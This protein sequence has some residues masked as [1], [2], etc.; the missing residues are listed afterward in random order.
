ML[1]KE[2]VQH[3]IHAGIA[4]DGSQRGSPDAGTA[5]ARHHVEFSDLANATG[6]CGPANQCEARCRTFVTNDEWISAAF[7]EVRVQIRIVSRMRCADAPFAMGRELGQTVVQHARDDVDR[8]L[9]QRRAPR[10]SRHAPW[11]R[12]PYADY[13]KLETRRND[14]I[15]QRPE[16]G[17]DTESDV[18][19]LQ[20]REGVSEYLDAPG[21][22]ARGSR[23]SLRTHRRTR[24]P[25]VAGDNRT[26]E[27][28]APVPTNGPQPPRP[29]RCS[30]ENG[31]D[32]P[33]TSTHQHSG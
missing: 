2:I 12:V 27:T 8:P 23:S 20:L 3:P 15:A 7:R 24:T 10:R 25:A 5:T 33:S 11:Q 30:R 31:R 26:S 22:P 9:A 21:P 18:P 29:P 17:H 16:V 1:T 28:F 13:R 6:R 14:R 32:Q 19:P 4:A